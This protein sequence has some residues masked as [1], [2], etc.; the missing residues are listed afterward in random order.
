M[1]V[2]SGTKCVY[3]ARDPI[4]KT[5]YLSMSVTEDNS[6]YL[7][8]ANQQSLD[9]FED[10]IT[11]G[12]E[13]ASTSLGKPLVVV[14]S[15]ERTKARLEIIDMTTGSLSARWDV[16]R[17]GEVSSVTWVPGATGQSF[18][19]VF[20]PAAVL[21]SPQ[22][23]PKRDNWQTGI[24]SLV[25]CFSNVPVEEPEE[26]FDFNQLARERERISLFAR[27]TQDGY[28][29]ERQSD[30]EKEIRQASH[31]SHDQSAGLFEEPEYPFLSIDGIFKS[32]GVYGDVEIEMESKAK[33]YKEGGEVIRFVHRL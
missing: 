13:T 22:D 31:Q 24:P 11:R 7:P 23:M 16:S 20:G 5:E 2:F 28:C 30:T 15:K 1:R 25:P 17:L 10:A 14:S 6:I 32:G 4:S 21:W 19:S 9:Y 27:V 26:A 29:F 12:V 18:V 33:I 8:L 3:E